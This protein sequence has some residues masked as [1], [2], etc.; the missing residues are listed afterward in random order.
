MYPSPKRPINPYLRMAIDHLVVVA[1]K[2]Q[3]NGYKKMKPDVM[4][5]SR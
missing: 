3:K 4:I 2:M 5:V 1:K